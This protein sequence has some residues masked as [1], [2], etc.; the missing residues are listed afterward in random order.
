MRGSISPIFKPDEKGVR[1]RSE[2]NSNISRAR[3]PE[4]E[5]SINQSIDRSVP[6]PSL[7]EDPTSP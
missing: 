4:H 6:V 1:D 5:V 7:C 2:L 3:I